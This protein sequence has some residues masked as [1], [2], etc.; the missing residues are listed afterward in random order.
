MNEYLTA[1]ANRELVPVENT[2]GCLG[3][4]GRVLERM[5]ER[6][7][8]HGPSG[9]GDLERVKVLA[10]CKHYPPGSETWQDAHA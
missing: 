8:R 9:P 10:G 7:I 5:D 4:E 2:C 1:Y 6:G 3:L